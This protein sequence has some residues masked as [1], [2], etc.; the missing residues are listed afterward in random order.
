MSCSEVIK[1]IRF[2]ACL[3][4][5]ELAKKIGISTALITRYENGTRQHPQMKTFRLIKA[6]AE[7]LDIHIT[8]EDI[9]K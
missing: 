2:K 1:K 6:Y 3:T 9:L 4:Q 7:T 8:Y 5:E